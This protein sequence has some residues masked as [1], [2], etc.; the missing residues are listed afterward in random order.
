MK[1]SSRWLTCLG[2]SLACDVRYRMYGCSLVYELIRAVHHL[3][4]WS[5][6]SRKRMKLRSP[7]GWSPTCYFGSRL[8]PR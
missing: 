6:S 4:E 5:G 8:D 3:H 2:G 1:G 7:H